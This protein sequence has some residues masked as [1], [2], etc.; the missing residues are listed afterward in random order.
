MRISTASTRRA[1]DRWKGR[2]RSHARRSQLWALDL[3]SRL[4]TSPKRGK[5]FFVPMLVFGLS[6]NFAALELVIFIL[7]GFFVANLHV[8]RFVN[9]MM[10]LLQ[11]PTQAAEVV[12]REEGTSESGL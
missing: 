2:A 6:V 12:G 1:I 9:S 8:Y 7:L 3:V 10:N 11:V 5:P 4:L